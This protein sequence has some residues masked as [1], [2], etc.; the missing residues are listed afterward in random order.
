MPSDPPQRPT[1][2]ES[3][4]HSPKKRS[5]GAA[6]NFHQMISQLKKKK[7]PNHLFLICTKG[8]CM[9]GS[10]AAHNPKLSQMQFKGIL[11]SWVIMK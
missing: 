1:S 4:N 11:A 8:L 10:H 6:L 2:K 9:A 7:N 3:E 5:M